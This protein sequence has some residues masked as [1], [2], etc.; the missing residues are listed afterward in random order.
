MAAPAPGATVGPYT[1]VRPLAAGGMGEVWVAAAADG[2]ELAVKVLPEGALADPAARARFAR[3]VTAAGSVDHPRVARV[4]AADG[5][6]D[7]PWLATELVVGPSLAHRV[8]QSGPL[9]GDELVAVARGLAEALVAVHAAGLVHR[10][11]TPANVVLGVDGPVLVDFGIALVP[12]ATT[13]TQ[14]GTVVGTAGWLAPEALRDEELTDAADVWSWGLVLAHAATGR[15]PAAASRPEAVLRRVLD[16]DLDL[17]GLPPWLDGLVRRCVAATPARRP[18]AEELVATLARVRPDEGPSTAVLSATAAL[19][20]PTAPATAVFEDGGRAGP[21]WRRLAV[22]VG[23]VV[24]GLVLGLLVPP[25]AVVLVVTMAVLVAVAVRLANERRADDDHP[26]VGAGTIV[27]AATAAVVTAG[28]QLVG[29]LVTLI[30]LTA[31]VVLF[32]ALGGDLG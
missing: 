26:L 5:E 31:L 28:A 3:E 11:V 2:A 4:L 7:R 25:L 13:L 18:T 16:G 10:D 6:A 32:L 29:L 19:P 30:G 12:E 22:Q 20:A 24:A 1:L 15:V 17:E 21:D 14:A 27:L 23:V 9:A 8:A